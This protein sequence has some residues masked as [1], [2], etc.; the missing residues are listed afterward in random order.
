MGGMFMLSNNYNLSWLH[1]LWYVSN[2]RDN[3]PDLTLHLVVIPY[4]EI[5]IA[6]PYLLQHE[7]PGGSQ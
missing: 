1:R 5:I 4:P 6:N 2:S 7:G 3:I